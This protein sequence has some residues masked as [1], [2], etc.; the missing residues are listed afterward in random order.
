VFCCFLARIFKLEILQETKPTSTAQRVIALILQNLQAFV[1]QNNH[2]S[3]FPIKHRKINLAA[4]WKMRQ[5]HQVNYRFKN[6][7][8]GIIYKCNIEAR[9]RN[10]CCRGKAINVTYSECVS[11]ALFAQHAKGTLCVMLSYVVCPALPCCSQLSHNWRYFRGE[12][13]EHKMCVLILCTALSEPFLILRR[14][15]RDVV[16]NVHMSSCKLPLI[17]VRF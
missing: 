16:I 11:G 9:S 7:K 3:N 12:V 10:H 6:N 2:C 4:V 1:P 13:I 15:Q 8:R 5:E 14:I 17:F